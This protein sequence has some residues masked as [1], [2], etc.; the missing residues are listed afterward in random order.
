MGEHQRKCRWRD[1]IDSACLPECGRTNR[2]EFLRGFGRDAADFAV[3][4]IIRKSQPFVAAKSTDVGLLA[5]EINSVL[6]IVFELLDDIRLNAGK[7][8]PEPEQPAEINARDAQQLI[9]SPATAI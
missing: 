3:V 9:G 1:A 4:Q 8:R 7:L 6:G 2:A 5:L